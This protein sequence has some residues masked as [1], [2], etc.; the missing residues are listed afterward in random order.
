MENPINDFYQNLLIPLLQK[1][2][3]LENCLDI[4]GNQ[5]KHGILFEKLA[6]VL[7]E[8]IKDESSLHAL[9]LFC[10]EIPYKPISL[11]DE[12]LSNLMSALVQAIEFH[13]WNIQFL[14]FKKKQSLVHFCNTVEVK[15]FYD[16]TPHFHVC[17]LY[18]KLGN[19]AKAVQT[20]TSIL[21]LDPNYPILLP[22]APSSF[23]QG[24][25]PFINKKED[26]WFCY[27]R[28]LCHVTPK[29]PNPL[30]F[31]FD[32][33][34]ISFELNKW[35]P[36]TN[37]TNILIYLIKQRQTAPLLHFLETQNKKNF[38]NCNMLKNNLA[39][40]LVEQGGFEKLQLALSIY[41]DLI[42]KISSRKK[43]SSL[44]FQAL[45]T[46]SQ[47]CQSKLKDSDEREK[48]TNKSYSEILKKAKTSPRVLFDFTKFYKKR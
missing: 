11:S 43:K 15:N 20:Y 34:K 2:L 1:N 44:Y 6:I 4:L 7:I 38:R 24:V 30:D 8:K 17:Q 42:D 13:H 21:Q 23:Y 19:I 46:F 48:I 41:L 37:I 18:L 26:K 27:Q 5:S 12:V 47:L 9:F 16:S 35:P 10:T 25:L 33:L 29:D 31:Y 28:L 3:I 32:F 22:Y 14:S 36:K 39:N 45:F 40:E